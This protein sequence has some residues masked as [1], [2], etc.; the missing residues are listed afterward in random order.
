MQ[1]RRRSH[2]PLAAAMTAKHQQDTPEQYKDHAGYND[3][4]VQCSVVHAWPLADDSSQIQ[5]QK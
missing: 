3:R 1:T 2:K 5:M 4:R